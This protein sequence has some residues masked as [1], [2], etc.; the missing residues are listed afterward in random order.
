MNRNSSFQLAQIARCPIPMD[1]KIMYRIGCNSEKQLNNSPTI[2]GLEVESKKHILSFK[3]G[4]A[5]ARRELK[6]ISL[7]LFSF[8]PSASFGSWREPEG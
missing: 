1:R 8:L 4:L 7:L 5:M 6:I 3:M 2:T